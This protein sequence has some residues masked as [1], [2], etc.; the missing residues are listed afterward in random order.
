M[1]EVNGMPATLLEMA[2]KV[3]D[4]F[5]EKG[6]TTSEELVLEAQTKHD[7][8]IA[9]AQE[10]HD[11]SILEA[12]STAASIVEDAQLT[13]FSTVRDANIKVAEALAAAQESKLNLEASILKLQEFESAYRNQLQAL[14]SGAQATLTVAQLAAEDTNLPTPDSDD[15]PS[16][17]NANF[18]EVLESAA[19]SDADVALVGAVRDVETEEVDFADEP[20]ET[21]DA[22]ADDV[23][24]S[25]DE[26]EADEEEA[27]KA[28]DDSEEDE[29]AESV[30]VIYTLVEETP[31][32]IYYDPLAAKSSIDAA[33]VASILNQS[34]LETNSFR[35]PIPAI[36]GGIGAGKSFTSDEDVSVI[37]NANPGAGWALT[38][39]DETSADEDEKDSEAAPEEDK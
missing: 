16:A 6:K 15:A 20:T 34:G 25:D 36:I 37:I 26:S 31:E 4:D 18:T 13:A 38:V 30:P 3:H 1:V 29:T 12:E 7:E 27:T 8:L 14:L 28:E 24:V 9:S 32:A 19:S 23:V 35:E 5:I 10:F 33:T 21:E 17:E 2:Q 22:P 39:E 11:I